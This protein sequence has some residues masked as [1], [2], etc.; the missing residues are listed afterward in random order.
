M[1]GVAGTA[2]MKRRVEQWEEVRDVDGGPVGRAWWPLG[3]VQ[4]PEQ[5][6]DM[7]QLPFHQ[8]PRL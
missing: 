2:V 8:D 6:S 3:P 4:S 1:L 5:R 7:I